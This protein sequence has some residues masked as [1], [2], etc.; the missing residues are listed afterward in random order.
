MEGG[1]AGGEEDQRCRRRGTPNWRCSERALDGKAFCKKHHLYLVLRNKKKR[2]EKVGGGGEVGIEKRKRKRQKIEEILGNEDVGLGGDG[3]QGWF[4]GGSGGGGNGSSTAGLSVGEEIARLFGEVSDG[5]GGGL[6]LDGESLQLWAGGGDG[7]AFDQG[8]CGNGGQV[9]GGGGGSEGIQGEF[10]GLGLEGEDIQLWGSDDACKNGGGQG[11]QVDG[12]GGTACGIDGLILGRGEGLS[13]IG[14]LEGFDGKKVQ[15]WSSGNAC[16]NSSG[17]L[18]VQGIHGGGF[19]ENAGESDGM[20]FGSGRYQ[21]LFSKV[22]SDTLGRI[23]ALFGEA[24]C[25]NSSLSFGGEGIEFWCEEAACANLD[26]KGVQ[27]LFGDNACGNGGEVGGGNDDKQELVESKGKRGRPK[28]SK[29]KK[30]S[31]G[32]EESIEGLSGAAGENVVRDEIKS[33]G[34]QGRS[35]GPKRKKKSL[36]IDKSERMT[37]QGTACLIA[38]DNEED[39]GLA[40]EEAI[41]G[42]EVRNESKGKR[43]RPKGS[44]NKKKNPSGQQHQGMPGEIVNNDCSDKIVWPIGLENEML[45]PLGEEEIIQTKERRGRPK[46]SKNKKTNSEGQETPGEIFQRKRSIGRPKGSKNKK[47]NTAGQENKGIASD[48]VVVN[49]GCD[50]AVLPIELKNKR[51]TFVGKEDRGL[52]LE[53]TNDSEG[54][55]EIIRPE[56]KPGQPKGLKTMQ[57]LLADKE[58]QVVP[59]KGSNDSSWVE[60]PWPMR[61][62]NERPT[63]V[64]E[65]DKGMSVEATGGNG[66]GIGTVQLEKRLGRPKGSKNKKKI[67]A[68][69][70]N[71]GVTGETMHRKD[72]VRAETIRSMGS[73]YERP[74][75]VGEEDQGMLFESTVGNGTA[76]ETILVTREDSLGGDVVGGNGGGDERTKK[77]R[78]RPKGLTQKRI[79]CIGEALKIE[80]KRQDLAFLSKEVPVKKLRDFG[81]IEMRHNELISEP[82]EV[83]KRPRGRPRKLKNKKR[84]SDG[85]TKGR[86][87]EDGL[88]NSGLS[89]DSKKNQRSLTCHQCWR[90]NTS[91]VVVCS[92]CKKR[93]YCYKCLE[94]WYPDKT[95][96]DVELACPFCRGN[97]NCR[98][99]LKEEV[100]VMVGHEQE[101]MDINTK[102]QKLLYLL[103]KTLPLLRHIQREQSS[104]LDVEAI[105]QGVKLME[106]D[107]S[108]S[109]L[110]DDDRVYC[111]SCNT[112]IVNIH[113]SCPNPDCSYD[114]CLTCC[115]ELRKGFQHGGDEA[116][117]SYQQ[118]CGQNTELNGQTANGN[119]YGSDSHVALPMNESMADMSCNFPDWR[120]EADGRIPCPPKVRGGCGREMLALKRIFEADW[121]NNLIKNSEDLIFKYQPPDNDFSQGCSLC[122]P[123]NIAG[124]GPRDSEVRQAAYR[125][126]SHDNF[127]YCPNAVHLGDNDFEHFQMHWMQGEPVIARNVLEK[128]SGLSW[129][130]M[131][132][133]RAFMGAK[134]ILKEEVA[135]FKAIDCL[136]WCEVEINIFRFFKGYLHGRSYRNG[137]PEMLKLKDWPASNSFEDCLPRHGAEFVAMLPFSDYTNPRSGLLNLA[138]K[139][140]VVLKPDLGPKTYIAYG[141]SEELSRGDSV[142]K[143]HCDI[144]DA[145]NVLTHTAEVKIPPRNK[146]FINKLKRKYEAEEL[147]KLSNGTHKFPSTSRGKKRKRSRKGKSKVH[148]YPEKA[149]IIESGSCLPE[150]L[151]IEEGTLDEQQNESLDLCKLG[152]DIACSFGSLASPE[153]PLIVKFDGESVEDFNKRLQKVD[154]HMC[155]SSSSLLGRNCE[156]ACDMVKKEV[157]LIE[158]SSPSNGLAKDTLLPESM[159]LKQSTQDNNEKEKAFG[160]KVKVDEFC[161]VK[162]QPDT[163]T[164][165]IDLNSSIVPSCVTGDFNTNVTEQPKSKGFCICQCRDVKENFSPDEI[166]AGTN[167]P[168]TIEICCARCK[169]ITERNI[170][171]VDEMVSSCKAEDVGADLLDAQSEMIETNL[172]NQEYLL[173]SS[174]TVTSRMTNWNGSVEVSFAGSRT[175]GTGSDPVQMDV[176]PNSYAKSWEVSDVPLSK[177]QGSGPHCPVSG[178]VAECSFT[179][180]DGVT[181]GLNCHGIEEFCSGYEGDAIDRK[182]ERDSCNLKHVQSSSITAELKSVNEE[183][184]SG[185]TV[186]G[187]IINNLEPTKLEANTTR[188]PLQ[189]NDIS[190]VGYGGAVWD[191]FRRQDVPKLIEY[192]QK[193]HK[194]FC[195]GSNLPVN[196]VIHPIH[197]QTLYLNEKHKKQ[198]K[199]EFGVEPWTFEQHLGEAVFI[200][201]G[202]P[203]Q[204]RNRQSCIK[205][206]LDFVSPENVQECIRLT[207]EFRLLPKTHRSKE[208]KLEV[209]KMALY[210]ASD[211]VNEAKNLMSKIDLSNGDK[212]A[213]EQLF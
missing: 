99:C 59:C 113:R 170:L 15:P 12:F 191:I 144:S 211:A 159:E 199:E 32:T 129:E 17:L 202:C 104:E 155:D 176:D 192:L 21:D 39:T 190:E 87:T 213:E 95:R 153:S 137:W 117:S 112:S 141:F 90:N 25:G 183:D 30:K 106:E 130:P 206:A 172:H 102:M 86:S 143:L 177:E 158:C 96:K 128:G 127:L 27:G 78:G 28:G 156:R 110:D 151:N 184:C 51:K 37:V 52:P 101:D 77:K 66:G 35:K 24:T 40:V 36:E 58:N 148:E 103:Y 122:H 73:E 139:L 165:V 19:I 43:G 200:P 94:K 198:L 67:V 125:E 152:S 140:P 185:A 180:S 203:H 49:D 9:L 147:R 79:I 75:L 175:E 60:T 126:S 97:C 208:D 189:K 45:T 135:R 16:G 119:R 48:I 120:A 42:N 14:G 166:I 195:H 85:I 150:R 169:N 88:E 154:L 98:V 109:V 29:N 149:D 193:H 194:E 57:N 92:N 44:K 5:N 108:R 71:E 68:N 209:K 69:Q 160:L 11:I 207:E 80:K 111:D 55:D 105:I 205:V 82:S 131:V 8:V 179:L 33:E 123:T 62:E 81:D 93:R 181:T 56:D 210:A 134:R 72:G 1:P 161:S 22:T 118:P 132:M 100:N 54:G 76:N 10:G 47:K 50:K 133:W 18:G 187:N 145:V 168:A 116:E 157:E 146:R 83:Q 121:V 167:H 136:D 91:D 178:T 53:A 34:M 6:G 162:N 201:A 38:L 163:C 65:E 61:Y 197:D 124:N 196:S 212:K 26:G 142:T 84:S 20:G 74:T 182:V 31:V 2:M 23:E 41:F 138:T 115:Q 188:D 63:H 64:S 7:Q 164:S 204:V 46:G 186:S 4:S 89:D 70:E 107:I 3:V 13:G 173:P 171:S 114:L 174:L